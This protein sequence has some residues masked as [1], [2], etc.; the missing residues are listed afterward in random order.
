M[1]GSDI[2]E[3]WGRRQLEGTGSQGIANKATVSAGAQGCRATEGRL[4]TISKQAQ[5]G[6]LSVDLHPADSAALE[7]GKYFILEIFIS[8]SLA[9]NLTHRLGKMKHPKHPQ[10]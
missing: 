7:K 2:E 4:G 9:P 6:L 1:T 8:L 3:K 5:G 10:P